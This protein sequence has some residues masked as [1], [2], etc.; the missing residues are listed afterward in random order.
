MPHYPYL[1][2]KEGEP[3]PLPNV[4]EGQQHRQ[5]EYIE[6][7]QYCNKQFVTLIDDILKNSK[8]PPIIVFMGDHGFRHFS[9]PVDPKYHFLNLNAV[10]LPNKNY[11]GFYK[12]MSG[13]NQFRTIL[14]TQFNKQLPLLKDSTF[15]FTGILI[16]REDYLRSMFDKKRIIVLAPHTD[17]G[18]LGCGAAI[19]K[20]CATGKEIIYVALSTCPQSLPQHLPSDTLSIECKQATKALGIPVVTFFCLILK[21]DSSH[22]P[23]TSIR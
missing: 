20:V 10:Y 3:N 7:L 19:A 11:G 12:G 15:I 22:T 8:Q 18:E 4:T 23:P 6:Y 9:E 2:N 1:F 16:K 17:D 14:N 13:V 5:K 21:C